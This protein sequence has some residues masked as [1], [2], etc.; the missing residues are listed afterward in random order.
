M[1]TSCNIKWPGRIKL[2]RLA[3]FLEPKNGHVQ[4]QA[5]TIFSTILLVEMNNPA[6]LTEEVNLSMNNFGLGVKSS[7]LTMAI[8]A[9]LMAGCPTGGAS[10]PI[11]WQAARNCLR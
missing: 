8:M 11:A 4:N 3:R 9:R 2:R 7:L 6:D 5:S 1:A 10:Y